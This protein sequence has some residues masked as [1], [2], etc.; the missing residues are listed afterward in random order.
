M[1]NDHDETSRKARK[2]LE[3]LSD[4]G[5]LSASPR[6]KQ[7]TDGLRRHFSASDADQTDSS[8]VW[9]TRIGR[10]LAAVAFVGLVLYLIFGVLG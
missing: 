4:Q 7:S 10:G 6:L 8:E 9:G 1:M 3:K 5:N 2:E